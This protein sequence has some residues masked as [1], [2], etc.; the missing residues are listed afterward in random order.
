M[1]KEK[2]EHMDKLQLLVDAYLSGDSLFRFVYKPATEE[3][4]LED[5]LEESDNGKFLYVPFKN[6]QE[7]YAEMSYF[8]DEQSGQTYDMLQD[9][10]LSPS[11]I[12]KFESIIE[13]AG[14]AE[15]WYKRK[16][17]YA[18]KHLYRWFVEVGLHI[19]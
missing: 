17:D 10:L 7:L 12:K 13:E 15:A 1:S 8:A 16:T 14:V 19:E 11:P 3:L 2:S 4:F 9:A 5:E 6:S 18:K